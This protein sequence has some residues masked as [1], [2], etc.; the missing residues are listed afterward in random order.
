MARPSAL[1]APLGPQTA[2]FNEHPVSRA[3]LT[4]HGPRRQG[5]GPPCPA[6]CWCCAFR[7]IVIDDAEC[8]IR[9]RTPHPGAA[10]TWMLSQRSMKP[11]RAFDQPA[12][13]LPEGR[14]AE[15]DALVDGQDPRLRDTV[16]PPALAAGGVVE[17]HGRDPIDGARVA[18]RGRLSGLELPPQGDNRRLSV[19]VMPDRRGGVRGRS[20]LRIS[21]AALD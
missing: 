20:S 1:L 10:R 12:D 5:P 7:A 8:A 14:R 19:A 17:D 3:G 9:P 2:S 18:R 13:M 4:S 15:G 16:L 6:P 21:A 11:R